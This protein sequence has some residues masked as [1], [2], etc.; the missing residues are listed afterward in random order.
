MVLVGRFTAGLARGELAE[1]ADELLA[2]H[3]HV[4]TSIADAAVLALLAA[5][6]RDDARQIWEAREPVERSYYWLAMT[7]LR[8]HAAVALGDVG[9]ASEC[10]EELQPY[11]GRV[12]GLDNGSLLAGPVDDALAAV[13]DLV[14]NDPEAR[15]YRAAAAALKIQLAAE[16]SQL[17][18]QVS[19]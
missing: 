6:R 10:A 12:A 16:A 4:S 18:D 14:G 11:S 3:L 2:V 17:V 8:A 9:A 7:T 13:A 19:R 1:L 5:G 15:R